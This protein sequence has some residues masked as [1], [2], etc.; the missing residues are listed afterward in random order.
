MDR[1]LRA[2]IWL[3]LAA[4]VVLVV[5]L[6]LLS[7]RQP[8]AR[9]AV[10]HAARENLKATISSNGKVEPITPYPI[11]AQFATFVEK[12]SVVEGQAVKRGQL[13]LTLE[14]EE[15][16]AALARAQEE[17]VSAQEDL[18]AARAGGPSGEVAQLES[19]M[20]KAE[21]ERD[22]L[23]R[24]RESLERLVARQAA[25]KDELDANH[26]SLER[27]D[28]EWQRLRKAKDELARR[29]RLDANRAGL[30]VERARSEVA[31]L[32]EKVRSAR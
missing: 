29:S 27:A 2:W 8:V 23:G 24:E 5:V 31:A 14:A 10:V 15:A 16:R 30:R 9:V 28:A 12:I 6:V 13:L 3:V 18:R 25:T 32:E 26:V 1:K 17:L 7:G 11:R 22:R 21:A 19:D 4:A 20:R